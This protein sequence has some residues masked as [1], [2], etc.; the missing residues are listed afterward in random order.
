VVDFF[1]G[2]AVIRDPR[3]AMDIE[4]WNH[5]PRTDRPFSSQKVRKRSELSLEMPEAKGPMDGWLSEFQ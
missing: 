5:E 1:L 4:T 3:P 2:D